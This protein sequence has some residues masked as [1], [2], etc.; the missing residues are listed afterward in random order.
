MAAILQEPRFHLP[1]KGPVGPIKDEEPPTFHT[2]EHPESYPISSSENPNLFPPVCIRS[3]WD[4]E[5][6][7]RR[8]LPST[9]VSLPLDP[10]PLTKVC[11]EYVTSS[12]FEMAPHPPESTVFP[13]GGS[14]YP[15]TRYRNATD[16]ESLLKGLDRPAGTCEKNQYLPKENLYIPNATV[17]ARGKPNDR[18]VQELAFPM[19]LMRSSVYDCRSDEDLKAMSKNTRMFNNSTKQNRN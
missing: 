10:R 7:I 16:N 15:P 14:F 3:H 6:I 12:A 8:T 4:P 13:S 9:R 17:P 2:S 5:N 19:A 1:W 18:F 11:M